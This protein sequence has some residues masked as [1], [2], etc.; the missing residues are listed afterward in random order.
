MKIQPIVA[1]TLFNG[2][3][4]QKRNNI[5]HYYYHKNKEYFWA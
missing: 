3:V 1:V 4:N 5:F 2:I